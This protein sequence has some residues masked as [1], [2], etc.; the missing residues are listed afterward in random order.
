VACGFGVTRFRLNYVV[1]KRVNIV[2]EIL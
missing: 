1:E 2:I